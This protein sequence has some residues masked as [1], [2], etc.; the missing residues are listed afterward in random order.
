MPWWMAWIWKKCPCITF[1]KHASKAN[2]KEHDFP[3]MEQRGLHNFWKLS[4]PMCAGQ[5][6][7]PCMVERDSFSHSLTIFQ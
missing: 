5:W 7:L 1:V 2:I 6:G 4:T 3:G